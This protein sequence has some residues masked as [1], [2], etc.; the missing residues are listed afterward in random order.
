MQD[1]QR[2]LR[3]AGELRGQTS[4]ELGVIRGQK[5]RELAGRDRGFCLT[6]MTQ[7]SCLDPARA[8]V[9]EFQVQR[10]TDTSQYL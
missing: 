3:V 6:Q 2:E 5:K 4:T 1:T 9:V 8:L 7:T 10:V